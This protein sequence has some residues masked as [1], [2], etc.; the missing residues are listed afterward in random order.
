MKRKGFTL[1]E[2]LV[3][4]AIIGILAAILLPALARAREAARRASCQNNLKQLGIVFKM[5][6]NES[7]GEVWPSFFL[8]SMYQGQV[9]NVELPDVLGGNA[10]LALGFGPTPP[11]IYPEYLTDVAVL[12]CP[13]DGNSSID[14]FFDLDGNNAFLQTNSSIDVRGGG[15][16]GGGGNCANA[17]D[18][19]YAYMGWILDQIE[20]DSPQTAISTA[21]MAGLA[22]LLGPSTLGI[23]DAVE[24]GQLAAAPAPDQLAAF[25][26][27]FL[28]GALGALPDV[29]ALNEASNEDIGVPSGAGNGGGDKVLRLRE[30]VE[31]FLITDIN[32]PGGSAKA[33]SAIF[34]VFD[35]VS[36]A[37]KDY[38]H[39]PG[40]CN[41]LYM[42]GHVEFIKYSGPAPVNDKLAIFTGAL[43]GL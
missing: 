20:T 39:V 2:L 7:E 38:S 18:E 35:T 25:F 8:K 12:L 13:S 28:S 27:G 9:D 11:E 26:A 34:T 17:V 42:D 22:A 29:A 3:V 14:A 40:G 23:L 31:R 32:N 24:A 10:D 16:C 6:A 33:Q 15:D 36:T 4:I 21:S 1:I 37:S 30:G 43:D 19:S 5:Y 41:V